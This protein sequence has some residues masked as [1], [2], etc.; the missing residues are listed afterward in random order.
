MRPHILEWHVVMGDAPLKEFAE[1]ALPQGRA[2][3]VR[4]VSNVSASQDATW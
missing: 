1:S 2:A 4:R 3:G